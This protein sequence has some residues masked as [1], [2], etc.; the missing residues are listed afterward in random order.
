MFKRWFKSDSLWY[1]EQVEAI[2]G[3]DAEKAF[4]ISG[5][6]AAKYIQTKEES[7]ADVLNGIRDGVLTHI[8]KQNPNVPVLRE[9]PGIG[10]ADVQASAT[11]MDGMLKSPCYLHGVGRGGRDPAVRQGSLL[12]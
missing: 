3:Y 1:S 2:P 8:V 5:P 11:H 12:R 10:D 7:V 6:V 4:I 9:L